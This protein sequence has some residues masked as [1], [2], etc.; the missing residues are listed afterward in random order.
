MH[1]QPNP[2]DF[3]GALKDANSEGLLNHGK[4]DAARRELTGLSGNKLT[5]ALQRLTSLFK[6]DPSACYLEVGVFQGLTLN[7]VASANPTVSCFGIVNFA[8]FDPRNE[9]M[10]IVLKRIAALGN[11]NAHLI[12]ADYED[13]LGSLHSRIGG[14]KVA[15]Y[16][17]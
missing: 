16:F 1:A 3:V 9:N 17:I 10:K 2:V 14:A 7:S 6:D 15:V 13:A 4:A 8:F 12:N 11:E 5:G